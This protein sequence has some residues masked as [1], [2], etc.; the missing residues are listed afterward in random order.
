MKMRPSVVLKN[1]RAG[2]VATSFKSNLSDARAVEIAA[3][4]GF[5]CIWTDLEHTANDWSVVEQQIWAAK[6]YGADILVRVAR[7]SYSDYIRA[8]ELDAAGIMVPHVMSLEDAQN[9]VRMTR[10]HPIGRRPVDSGNADG[11]YCNIDF[12]EYIAQANDQRFVIL[13]IEDPEPL[14]DLEAIAALDGIDMLFFGP[15]DFSHGIG[16]PAQWDH[17]KLIETRKRVAEVCVAHGKFAGTPGTPANLD[18]LIEMGYRF[19]NMG[20]DVLALS[21]YCSGLVAEFAKRDTSA[22]P[23]AC[24]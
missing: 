9:V 21:Q 12:L 10:F 17:P 13:Q 24:K 2:K 3:M 5:D 14:D 18:E 16:A 15:A 8:L 11:S 22:N 7:G 20:A 1:L 23:C 19:I 4:S 6:A